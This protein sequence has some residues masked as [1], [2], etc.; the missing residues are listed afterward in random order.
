MSQQRNK[1]RV[2]AAKY[3]L[4][5]LNASPPYMYRKIHT[6]ANDCAKKSIIQ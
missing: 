4:Y 6:L 3:S 5:A 1:K 2:G